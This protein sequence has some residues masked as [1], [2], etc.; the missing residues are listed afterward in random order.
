MGKDKRK[1]NLKGIKAISLQPRPKEVVLY[2]FYDIEEDK[3]R[4]RVA[5]TCKDYGLE[6]I[7]FSGFL[8]TLSVNKREELYLKL[9]RTL[10]EKIGR[11]LLQPVCEKD[12]KNFTE[13]INIEE[14][15]NATE[16]E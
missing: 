3:I 11:I 8:G 7:Q 15:E 9:A 6:R 12:F 4:T 2:V 1:T 16:G 5:N 10:G 14:E 13:I